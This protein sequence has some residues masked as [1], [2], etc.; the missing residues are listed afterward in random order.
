[1]K[2]RII[3]NQIPIDSDVHCKY[4]CP[5]SDCNI[6][7]W[8]SLKETQTKNFKIVCECGTIFQPKRIKKIKICFL[9]RMK[10]QEE[11]S[12]NT[13]EEKEIDTKC[14]IDVEILNKASDILCV[15]GF[16]KTEAEDL[17][18]KSYRDNCEKD[19]TLLVKQTLKTLEIKNG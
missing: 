14:N 3:K 9:K 18:I 2:T 13:V 7:H 17:I 6:V 12:I 8:L 10:K 1:M 11:A 4:R 5:S 15:Y 19:I 16:T